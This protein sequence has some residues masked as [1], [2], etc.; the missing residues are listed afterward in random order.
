MLDLMNK[1]YGQMS[2][3]LELIFSLWKNSSFGMI[4]DRSIARAKEIMD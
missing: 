1:K 3:A 4:S 2:V